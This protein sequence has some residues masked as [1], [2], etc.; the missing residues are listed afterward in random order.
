METIELIFFFNQRMSL[1]THGQ[2][3]LALRQ[4]LHQ[5]SAVGCVSRCTAAA[6]SRGCAQL[7]VSSSQLQSQRRTAASCLPAKA[8]ASAASPPQPPGKPAPRKAKRKQGSTPPAMGSDSN[9]TASLS[10]VA[11]TSAPTVQLRSYQKDCV[12]AVLDLFKQGKRRLAISLATGAGK[13]T[14]FSRII[15]ECPP[16]SPQATKT[17]V[18]CHRKEL[19]EQAHAHITRH[20]PHLRVELE[21]NNSYA[22]VEACDV[23]IGSVPSLGRKLTDS[24]LLRFRPE[25][26]KLVI[27]DEAHHSAADTYR[28]IL[29]HFGLWPGEQDLQSDG[30]GAISP[31]KPPAS[32]SLAEG[33][34]LL[35]CTATLSR[36][37]GLALDCFEQI[38][39]HMPTKQLV[40]QKFLVPP[41]I[42]V[43]RRAPDYVRALQVINVSSNDI[44][45]FEAD[46]KL[47]SP[48]F[49]DLILRTW[50]HELQA[51]GR[52]SSLFF[53]ISIAQMMA[54]Q[55]AFREAG[56][57][58]RSVAGDTD[59]EE[60]A[61]L[62]T[63]FRAREFPVLLNVEVM[64][65]GV[66]VPCIDTIV[67]LRPTSSQTLFLQMLGRGLRQYPGK[68]NCLVIDM[69]GNCERLS[70]NSEP[71]LSGL[72]GTAAIQKLIAQEKEAAKEK[73]LADADL[74]V[75]EDL[76]QDDATLE[77]RR[78]V[79]GWCFGLLFFSGA[80]FHCIF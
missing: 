60:R 39:F 15:A 74:P 78:V 7:F 29:E 43:P 48:E 35:G 42:R 28:T 72:S 54:L 20:Y 17:L 65:E 37:D 9:A 75:D 62:M 1:V 12:A 34:R 16:A 55:N 40:Q 11:A 58:A 33:P 36:N 45:H 68:D 53:C 26:F 63:A 10:T 24:R 50:Q 19:L 25:H 64:T 41:K 21:A 59:P 51:E 23:I 8:P 69:V 80:S 27:V 66:D 56:I 52:K 76:Q 57:D 4:L 44:E 79:S 5:A 22:N 32:T 18:L 73:A 13:T 6:G 31:A 46:E 49:C 61:K 70:L 67:F 77:G 2:R 30:G 3:L 71:N 38:A 14:I 47:K